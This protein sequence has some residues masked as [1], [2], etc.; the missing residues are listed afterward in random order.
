L[1]EVSVEGLE[2]RFPELPVVRD[3]P[4]GARE[5]RGRQPAVMDPAVAR[6]R[7]QAGVLENA[8]VLGNGRQRDVER[9]GELGHGRLAVGEARHH[10]APG[11]IGERAKRRVEGA[12]RGCH[13]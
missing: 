11:G 2:L 10:R 4:G 12:R 5:R 6:A 1:A 7:D 3:P 13:R 8:K 9:L